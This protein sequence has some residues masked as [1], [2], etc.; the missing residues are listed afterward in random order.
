[1]HF[2][3]KGVLDE[4]I[5]IEKQTSEEMKSEFSAIFTQQT[6]EDEREQKSITPSSRRGSSSTRSRKSKVDVNKKITIKNRPVLP[7]IEII[8]DSAQAL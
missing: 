6:E 3:Y 7:Q 2:N 1:M 5:A 8:D 4:F